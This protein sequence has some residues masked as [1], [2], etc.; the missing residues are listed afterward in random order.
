MLA[1]P[2]PLVQSDI[3]FSISAVVGCI[4]LSSVAV[5][6]LAVSSSSQ[7]ISRGYRDL[8]RSPLCST[9]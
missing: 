7:E 6:V 1:Q 8:T 2:N 3:L 4:T 9:L 5:V